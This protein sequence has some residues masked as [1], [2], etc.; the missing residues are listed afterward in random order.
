MA[1][2]SKTS[3]TPA[4]LIQRFRAAK[5]PLA[6]V[7]L[8]EDVYLRDLCRKTILE[9]CVPA[10]SRDWAVAAISAKEEGWDAA[11]ERARTFPMLSAKQLVILED[12]EALESLGEDESSRVADSM[13]A[14]LADPAPFTILLIEAR[15]LD[16]R[17]RFFKVLSGSAP[18][19]SLSS[20][21]DSAPQAAEK[22]ARDAGAAIEPAA[23][24]ALAEML[25][26]GLARIHM[27]IQKLALYAEGRTITLEDV[28]LLVVAARRHT[29]WQ[30]ADMLA[31]RRRGEAL[32]FFDSLMRSGEQPA[33][34]VGALA[35]MYRTLIQARGI[36][37][38]ASRYDVSR[39]LRMSP[40]RAELAMR[41]ARQ[42][43][44]ESLLLGLRLLAEADSQL[45]SGAP[46]RS[47]IMEFLIAELTGIPSAPHA[48]AATSR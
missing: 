8:G 7:L 5:P 26:G 30:L 18:F 23:A 9:V 35:W 17:R 16:E 20:D 45:K 40:E 38:G 24:A 36:P 15:A 33:G 41:N 21:R 46:D 14:Y 27:E 19:V 1:A 10:A 25:D 31:A 47:A 29:V 39:I 44:L 48:T 13:A 22:M 32:A 37:A 12:A 4:G 34:I 3:L 28:E 6:V 2:P 11:L 43:P 42:I